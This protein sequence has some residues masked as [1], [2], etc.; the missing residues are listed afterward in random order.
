MANINLSFAFKDGRFSLCATLRGTSKDRKYRTVTNLV[1]PNFDYWDTKQQ[2]FIEP[3][4]DA[5]HNNNVLHEMKGRYQQL[6]DTFH[7]TTP[8]ELFSLNDKVSKVV[9]KEVLTLGMYLKKLIEGMKKESNKR[10]SKAYQNYINLLHK[11]EKEGTIINRPLS[12]ICDDDFIRFGDFLLTL[13]KKEGKSNYRNLMKMFKQVHTKATRRRLN[14]HTLVYPYLDDAPT[15]TSKG[16]ISLDKEQYNK[17]VNYDLHFIPQSGCEPMFYKELYRDFCIFLYEV[18]MR[19]CDVLCLHTSNINGEIIC[20]T[21]EKKKNYINEDRRKVITPLTPIA[22]QIISKYKGQSSKGY[23][24]PFSMNEYDW[25]KTDAISWNK[26]Q[27]RKQ[28][29]LEDINKFLH[30]FEKVLKLDKGTFTTYV[31][32]H[33][34]LTYLCNEKGCN[35]ILIAKEAGTSVKMLETHYYHQQY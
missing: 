8:K 35:L 12:D 17:F 4:Q 6:I 30:K 34:R 1:N 33:S 32:R 23:I 27:N 9:A 7:P 29:H 19:P 24:F 16:R 5:I 25:D 28:K 20:Y 26:W 15:T 10:P 3:T 2:R 31:F 14:S 11:L 22:K 21:P 18:K 13:N